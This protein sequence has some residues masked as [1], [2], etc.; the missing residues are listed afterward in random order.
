MNYE[1]D[2]SLDRKDYRVKEFSWLSFNARL[3]QEA[4]D[5][6]VPLSERI[7]FL[8]IYSSNLDEFFEVR[9]AT[10]KRLATLGKKGV[11]IIGFDPQNVISELEQIIVRQQKDFNLSYADIIEELNS[12]KIFIINEKELNEK[13][14][15]FVSDYFHKEIRH[16]IFPIIIS[17][18]WPWGFRPKRRWPST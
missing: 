15:E 10:L 14:S 7:K 13:Q 18:R 5:V 6:N 16:R 17:A 4:R 3:L 8:G 12:N 2:Y 11:K 9:V 1:K